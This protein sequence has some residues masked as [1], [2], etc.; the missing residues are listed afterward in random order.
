MEYPDPDLK[1]ALSAPGGPPAILT[2]REDGT[3]VYVT[4]DA[5]GELVEEDPNAR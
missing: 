1:A 2:T 4:L 3:P 5:S